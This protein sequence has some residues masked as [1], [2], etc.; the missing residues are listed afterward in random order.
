MTA[1][2]ENETVLALYPLEIIEFVHTSSIPELGMLIKCPQC[3]HYLQ[4][5]LVSSDFYFV[6]MKRSSWKVLNK[7]NRSLPYC[8]L[9]ILVKFVFNKPWNQWCFAC[10]SAEK[11]NFSFNSLCW[12]IWTLY[13][14]STMFST[15]L[16]VPTFSWVPLPGHAISWA[17]SKQW[18]WILSLHTEH[19]YPCLPKGFFTKLPQKPHQVGLWNL[20]SWN[21]WWTTTDIKHVQPNNSLWS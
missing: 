19:V 13:N 15:L 5:Y 14:S 12:W 18:E 17:A 20:A 21:T 9:N 1:T 6:D 8:W 2:Q 10:L 4:L 11:N 16:V 3:S 7:H